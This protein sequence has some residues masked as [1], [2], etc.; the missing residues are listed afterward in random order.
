MSSVVNHVGLA[1]ADIARS[2]R[3][4]EEVLGFEFRNEITVPDAAVS[5]MFLLDEP[6]GMRAAYLVRD[7]FVLE[8]MA[9]ENGTVTDWRERPFNEPGL[10]HLSICVDD[11]ED[12]ESKAAAYGGEVLAARSFKG[13]VSLIRDPDGQLLELLPMTYRDTL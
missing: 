11:I 7:G 2:R 10:T 4:Y 13:M 1:V 12:T 6:I 8:L 3:F 9:F 5:H